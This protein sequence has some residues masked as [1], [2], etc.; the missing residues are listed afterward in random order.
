V[1]ER[2][3]ANAIQLEDQVT[4]KRC[5]HFDHK[6]IIHTQEMVGKV[7]AAVD[8]RADDNVMIIARTDA[9]AEF[10]LEEACERAQRYQA[11]GADVM[12]IEAPHDLAEL[13]AIPR[14]VSGA[15]VANMVEGGLT[16]I[17]PLAELA[18]FG[19]SIVLY[20]NT[21][22]RAAIASM[23]SVAA[24]LLRVG[25]SSGLTDRIASW[26]ERQALVRKDKFDRLDLYY[27]SVM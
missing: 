6:G 4:P 2:A 19:F 3:G 24:E 26:A 23:Q 15:H 25:D 7:K 14:L 21:A 20:A 16:P 17:V 18:E 27:G 8:A 12:F 11:A 22:M 10:G 9:R 1:L 5:G 13:A